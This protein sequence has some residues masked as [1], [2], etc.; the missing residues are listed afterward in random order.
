MAEAIL[1]E[2]PLV[3]GVDIE[4]SKPEAPIKATFHSVSV[5]I[6]REWK[7]AYI[8]FGSNMGDRE[9]Y[10]EDALDAI[11][12]HHLIELKEVS[13]KIETKPYGGVKQDDFLNGVCHIRTIM[14]QSKGLLMK[15]SL[16]S[17]WNIW[18]SLSL[19]QAEKERFTGDRE[20]WTLI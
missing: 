1:H 20:P 4:V 14:R 13:T 16:R 19:S 2:Y 11:A 17:Y 7:D 8:A 3:T 10:I 6:H 12:N 18:A 5:E 9:G 15:K